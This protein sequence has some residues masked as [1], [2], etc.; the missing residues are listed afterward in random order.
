L[1][2]KVHV[3]LFGFFVQLNF[4]GRFHNVMATG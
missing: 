1:F 2:A 3:E 4:V